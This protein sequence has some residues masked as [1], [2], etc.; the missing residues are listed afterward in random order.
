MAKHSYPEYMKRWRAANKAR[1]KEW[2]KGWYRKNRVKE[3]ARATQR[4]ADDY[5]RHLLLCKVTKANLTYPGRLTLKDLLTVIERSGR[6]CYW[7]GKENLEGRDLTLEHLQPVN[8]VQHL[9]I[10]CLTCNA[11]RIQIHGP[12]KTKAEKQAAKNAWARM[13]RRRKKE[14]ADAL[15]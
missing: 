4:V 5:G 14:R 13:D 15:L 12:R 9:T 3:I 2:A 6:R 1:I 10:A 11:A 7:C 8:D